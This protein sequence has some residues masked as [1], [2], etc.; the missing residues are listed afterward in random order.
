MRDPEGHSYGLREPSPA[1]F[2]PRA[3]RRC[4]DYLYGID[5]YNHGYYWEAH[6]SWEGIWKSTRRRDLP[7]RFL[8]GLIQV[9][10]ALLKH[11][12]G[13]P[14]GMRSLAR[15]GLDKLQEVAS[16]HSTYCGLD[17]DRLGEQWGRFFRNPESLPPPP[18]ALLPRGERPGRRRE[19]RSNPLEPLG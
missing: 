14:A 12:M 15:K 1:V 9:A 11:R 16:L 17:L 8:Q 3:W 2:D 18:L 5:L 7:G 4:E 19:R 6:E 13:R 10:A